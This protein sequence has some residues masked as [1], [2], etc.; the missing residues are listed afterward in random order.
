MNTNLHNT[1]IHPGPGMHLRQ[2]QHQSSPLR[3]VVVHESHVQR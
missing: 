3:L 2:R 1:H